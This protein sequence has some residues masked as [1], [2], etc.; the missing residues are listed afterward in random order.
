M[1]ITITW[2]EA[3]LII[4]NIS[5]IYWFMIAGFKIAGRRSLGQLGPHEFIL[6][7]LFAELMG[8][9]VVP[10]KTGLLGNLVAGS[11]L[12]FYVWLLNRFTWLRNRIQGSPAILLS[13]GIP[14][15]E[16]LKH[17]H[18]THEDLFRAARIYGYDHYSAFETIILEK[19]GTLSGVLKP[20]HR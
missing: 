4:F 2:Q 19:N 5:I 3:G 16:T 15:D 8:N 1:D 6:V 20:E 17:Y 9:R 14:D 12:L 18:L 10:E 11:T 13:N 7:V